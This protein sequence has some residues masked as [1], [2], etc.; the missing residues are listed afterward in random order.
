M[1]AEEARNH[2]DRRG[3]MRRIGGSRPHVHV[4][5][6]ARDCRHEIEAEVVAGGRQ[7]V[8]ACGLARLVAALRDRDVDDAQSSLT[9]EPQ[10]QPADDAFVIGMRREDQRARCIRGDHRTR[11]R[12]EAAERE[13]PAL[14]H[15]ARELGDK[16]M[17]GRHRHTD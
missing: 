12:G 8:P 14:A 4:F 11:R 9:L 2:L 10:R 13:L 16:V 6:P 5:E 17:V 7:L 15:E 1:L 3:P